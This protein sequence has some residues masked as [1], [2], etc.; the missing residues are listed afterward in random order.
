[1]PANLYAYAR[2]GRAGLGNLLVPWARCEVFAANHNLP[3]LAP[4]WTQ[5]KIGPILRG[6]RDK[7]YYVGLFDHGT[8]VRGLKRLWLLARADKVAEQDADAVVASRPARA[9]VIVFSG[10]GDIMHMFAPLLEHR[11]L[12]RRRLTAILSASV[13]ARLDA[14]RQDFVI[15]AHVRRGDKPVLPFGQVLAPRETSRGFADQWF[16]NCISNIR[17]VLGRPVPVMI[18]S[19]ARREQLSALLALENVSLAGENPSIMDIFL[20][21][22]SKVLIASGHSTFSK[23]ASFLGQMPSLWYPGTVEVLNP[24]CPHC[25]SETALDGSFGEGFAALLRQRLP[26]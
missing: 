8:Y 18:F 13:K 14:F 16:I 5:P 9:T 22:R 11:E 15:G 10:L 2:V 19:D 24:D 17:A 20:M 23:W 25:E 26:S 6:E 3:V 1:M 12:I 7:R 4:Q 21:S